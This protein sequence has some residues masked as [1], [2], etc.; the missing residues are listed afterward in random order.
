[1][2]G[3]PELAGSLVDGAGDA[4][5]PGVA[6]GVVTG[7]GAGVPG[8]VFGG[9]FGLRGGMRPARGFVRWVGAGLRGLTV[10]GFTTGATDGRPMFTV[11]LV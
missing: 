7:V 6:T 5:G 2:V 1:V 10:V 4:V 9:V 11:A 8:A 3:G